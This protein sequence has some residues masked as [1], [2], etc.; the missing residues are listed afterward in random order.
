MANN[1]FERNKKKATEQDYKLH[2]ENTS[3]SN[4]ITKSV[5]FSAYP[6]TEV[7]LNKLIKQM[8][9]MHRKNANRSTTIRTAIAYTLAQLAK[10]DPDIDAEIE[11]ALINNA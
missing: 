4:R 2:S 9:R 5:G 11:S 6:E 3:E 1:P 10:K 8:K 7:E